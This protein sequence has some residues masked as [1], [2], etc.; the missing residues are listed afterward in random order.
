MIAMKEAA[1]RPK[2]KAMAMEYRG[3]SD[4]LRAADRQPP[5]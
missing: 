2:D 1:G 5:T 3:L 4:E